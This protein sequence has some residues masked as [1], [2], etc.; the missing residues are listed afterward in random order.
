MTIGNWLLVI[1]YLLPIFFYWER[2]KSKNLAIQSCHYNTIALNY[3]NSGCTGIIVGTRHCRF[4]FGYRNKRE[5][6][7]VNSSIQNPKSKIQNPKSKI[8][9]PKS[10]DLPPISVHL[11][12]C[13]LNAEQVDR[14]NWSTTGH[15][16]K[17]F[18]NFLSPQRQLV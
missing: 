7:G 16:L 5:A 11:K 13:S 18:S 3:V 15:I 14:I 12:R 10:I 17:N 1:S 6:E 4:Q 2:V 8:Q 9:N